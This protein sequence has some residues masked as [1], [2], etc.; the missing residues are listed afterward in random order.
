MVAVVGGC[1]LGACCMVGECLLGSC[2]GVCV[3][4]HWLLWFVVVGGWLMEGW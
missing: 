4:G 1:L 2:F 3:V